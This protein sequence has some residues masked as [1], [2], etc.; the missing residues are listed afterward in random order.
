MGSKFNASGSDCVWCDSAP[1]KVILTG[2]S[3]ATGFEIRVSD[4]IFNRFLF[5]I[6]LT[7]VEF[8]S[9]PWNICFKLKAWWPLTQA[10]CEL[11]TTA[12]AQFHLWSMIPGSLQLH[13]NQAPSS[14]PSASKRPFWTLQWW[15]WEGQ[16]LCRKHEGWNQKPK[17]KTKRHH[18]QGT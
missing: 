15:D 4:A 2:Q 8:G 13:A 1:R 6:Y 12:L 9:I 3:A 10:S 11:L 18:P 7:S 17:G 5:T 14:A 16:V